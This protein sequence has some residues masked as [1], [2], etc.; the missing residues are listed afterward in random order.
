MDYDTLAWFE[1][2]E[3]AFVSLFV[4][5]SWAYFFVLRLSL[6]NFKTVTVTNID[7]VNK[8]QLY[9]LR[10]I[11][12]WK[13]NTENKHIFSMLLYI[14]LYFTERKYVLFIYFIV[15][16]RAS[17]IK[18]ESEFIFHTIEKIWFFTKITILFVKIFLHHYFKRYWS[19]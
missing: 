19:Y 7:S 4:W 13:L 16:P 9:F 3:K 12:F 17:S 2:C 5:R 11:S 18:Y 8:M 15:Q 14:I 1:D 10:S 6:N